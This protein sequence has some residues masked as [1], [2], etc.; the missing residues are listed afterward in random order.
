MNASLFLVLLLAG[1]AVMQNTDGFSVGQLFGEVEKAVKKG[2]EEVAQEVQTGVSAGVQK[3]NK[4]AVHAANAAK[5]AASAGVEIVHQ[6]VKAAENAASDHDDVEKTQDGGEAAPRKA[7]GDG[8]E[9]TKTAEPR[10][11][12]NVI[13]KL[14]DTLSR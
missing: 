10:S 14:E 13:T 3:A 2:V 8:P 7:A 6:T 5:K 12:V 9:N 1:V 11:M 4:E